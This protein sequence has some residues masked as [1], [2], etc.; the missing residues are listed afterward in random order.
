MIK[1]ITEHP[2][3]IASLDHIN[4][5][6]CIRDNNSFSYYIL[7]VKKYFNNQKINVLDLG[8]AGGQI[9]I[10]HLNLGDLA[11]GLEGSS[12]A[13]NGAG[14][15]NWDLYKD[16]NLFLCD[17]TEKF[18]IL[19]DNGETIKFDIIQMWEVL[20]HIPENKLNILLDNIKKHLKTNGIF[21]GSVATYHCISGTHVS[22]FEKSKWSEIFK[23]SGFDMQP[24]C[25]NCVPRPV[26]TGDQGFLFTGKTI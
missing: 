20:E 1:V 3:A 17:I 2:I 19:D 13:L 15:H 11:V 25:F 8:C 18:S 24:Y 22:V 4:P 7:D 14:K 5:F 26:S 23:T 21:I 10:D 9:I 12:H 6:G 16:K